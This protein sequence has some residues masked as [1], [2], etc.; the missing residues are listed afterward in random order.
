MPRS[1]PA[2]KGE[3]F[4]AMTSPTRLTKIKELELSDRA[5]ISSRL[6]AF[7]PEI[8][9]HTFTN[10]FL[11]RHFRKINFLHADDTLVFLT[12]DDSRDDLLVLFGP[13]VGPLPIQD[14]ITSLGSRFGGAARVPASAT[15]GLNREMLIINKDR[16]NGDYVYRVED[17]ATLPG[18]K[19]SK[20]RNLVRQCRQNYDTVYE[21]INADNIDQC[22]AMQERWC[23]DRHCERDISL[24]GEFQAIRDAFRY[25]NDLQLIGG[26]IRLNGA[27]E[28][29]A[30][31]EQL[32]TDT[33]V[34][35]FEKASPG[36][37]G[38][39]QLINTSFASTALGDF[40]Y[41]NR[42]Q[43]LGIDGLRQAKKS[44]HPDHM[45]YKYT[46]GPTS[47]FTWQPGCISDS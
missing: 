41:V 12:R 46:I 21:P 47:R 39:G 38:L 22:L 20:K 13:P 25:F 45:V 16:D 11:W 18:R 32:H 40:Q 3:I 24:C 42:E 28:A 17:L 6:K 14:I 44:Y 10:L 34:C 43:D 37:T 4:T 27:I 1:V 36:F 30:I 23:E 15:T 5:A 29:F 8:S 31:G 35:H 7:P 33:A 9:E 2:I 19:Y 26:A